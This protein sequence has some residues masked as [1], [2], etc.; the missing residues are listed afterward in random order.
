M[1]HLSA[2][3]SIITVREDIYEEVSQGDYLIKSFTAV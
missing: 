3:H 2:E 1:R